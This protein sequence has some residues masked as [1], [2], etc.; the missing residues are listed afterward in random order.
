MPEVLIP[1][2]LFDGEKLLSRHAVVIEGGRIQAVLPAN[3]VDSRAA[4]PASPGTAGAR[5]SSTSRSMAA[6]ESSSTM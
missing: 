4:P 1:E 6:A 3:A 2:R 5:A